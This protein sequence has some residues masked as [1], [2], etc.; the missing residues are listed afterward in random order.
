MILCVEKGWPLDSWFYN[1]DLIFESQIFS[2]QPDI[3]RFQ[4]SSFRFIYKIPD[5]VMNKLAVFHIVWK[6]NMKP[7][8]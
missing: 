3:C 2:E 1:T 5:L 7:V 4:S 8:I 6:S